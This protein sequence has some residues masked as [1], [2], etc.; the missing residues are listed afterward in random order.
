MSK[1]RQSFTIWGGCLFVA[2]GILSGVGSFTFFYAKGFSYF[3]DDPKACANCH[4]MRGQ[5]DG[6]NRSSH[7]DVATCNDCHTPHDLI[8]KYAT[9]A[10][11]GWNHSAAFT[12]G[13]FEEPIQI[14]HFN[15]KIARKNCLDCHG[16]LISTMQTFAGSEE[17]DCVFC[18]GNV[19]HNTRD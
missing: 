3:H 11:N 14:H 2:L 15:A 19:G 18:H 6:W 17:M 8:G 12:T 7:H 9:K 16:N 10:I 1:T 5:Y 4:I 13:R